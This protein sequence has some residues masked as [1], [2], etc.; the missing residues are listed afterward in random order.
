MPA[1]EANGKSQRIELID[2]DTGNL[3]SVHKM[4][5]RVGCTVRTVRRA[6]DLDG[7]S[8]VLLPG[9]GH[10]SKAAEALE[11]SGLRP[12]LDQLQRSGWPILGICVGAQLMCRASEEGPGEGLGW[13]PT[14]VRRFPAIDTSGHPLRVPHWSGSRSHHHRDVCRLMYRRGGF[15]LPIRSTWTLNLSDH[16]CFAPL[17]SAACASPRLHERA[18]PWERSF[19]PKRVTGTA[20]AF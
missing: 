14:V 19:I 16:S 9:V 5:A 11:M 17:S 1:I 18:M 8:P 10:F 13:F 2:L 20:W 6:E 3:G 4:L 7:N 12:H 15:I